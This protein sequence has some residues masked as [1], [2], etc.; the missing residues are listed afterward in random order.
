MVAR[1]SAPFTILT[2]T[3][4]EEVVITN[5]LCELHVIRLACLEYTKLL[6][7][8][9][10]AYANASRT[11]MLAHNLAIATARRTNA[12]TP[13]I[14]HAYVLH[15]S[16]QVSY[17]LASFLVVCLESTTET[18]SQSIQCRPVCVVPPNWPPQ[19]HCVHY[20]A[21]NAVSSADSS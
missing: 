18:H 15:K 6:Y 17:Y 4:Y 1:I 10:V 2:M 3:I 14:S 8:G 12:Q 11:S 9:N 5:T 20:D 16:Y 7:D 19:L 21:P 13:L